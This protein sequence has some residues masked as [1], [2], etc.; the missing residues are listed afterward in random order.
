MQLAASGSRDGGDDGTQGSYFCSSC[1]TK[2]KWFWRHRLTASVAQ[3]LLTSGTTQNEAMLKGFNSIANEQLYWNI[4]EDTYLKAT[5]Q[6]CYKQLVEPLA[7]LYSDMIAFQALTICHFSKAQLSRAWENM[8]GSNGW[9]GRATKIEKQSTKVQGNISN[10]EKREERTM[11]EEAARDARV[12]IYSQRHLPNTQTESETKQSFSKSSHQTTRATRTSTRRGWKAHANRSS[13]TTDSAHG[14]T[15]RRR[16]CSGS[17]L[18]PGAEN[19]SCP[20]LWS[21]NIGFPLRRHT[22]CL[23][24]LF[25]RWRRTPHTQHRRFIRY[26]SSALYQRS[27]R[28]P[29]QICVA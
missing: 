2:W 22:D 4:C 18:V 19:Q 12:A 10:L 29:N 27:Y 8:A 23:P 11:E 3:K 5:E 24:F 26:S 15:L 13:T 17:L 20:E 1:A 6:E 21:T 14:E 7:Q 25:Q 16:A 9:E 28:Q